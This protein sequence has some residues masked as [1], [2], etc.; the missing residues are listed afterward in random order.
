MNLLRTLT[1][2]AW[3]AME[4]GFNHNGDFI[5][6]LDEWREGSEQRR[7]FAQGRSNSRPCQ[8]RIKAFVQTESWKAQCLPHDLK[9]ALHM[10]LRRALTC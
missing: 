9:I 8:L 2:M 1:H 7:W 5:H 10:N 6:D 4:K 3:T